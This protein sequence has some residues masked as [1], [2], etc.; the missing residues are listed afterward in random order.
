MDKFETF[1]HNLKTSVIGPDSLCAAICSL[2]L[3]HD[4]RLIYHQYQPH[5]LDRGSK[6]GVWQ[7]PMEISQ[8][9]WS[10]KDDLRALGVKSFLDIG[11]FNGYTFFVIL[12]F[13][14]AFVHPDL[15]ALSIDPCDEIADEIRPYVAAYLRSETSQDVMTRHE[16]YDFVFIDGCH[17]APW[18]AMDFE[19]AKHSLNAKMVMFHDIADRWCPAVITLFKKITDSHPY[20]VFKLHPSKVFGVGLVFLR[21]TR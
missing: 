1:R 8:A 14:K 5:M 13:L 17:E 19:T 7:D 6:G 15:T 2:G 11:T 3:F 4:D 20:K 12:E 21:E 9:L 16:Q 18:P 10:L